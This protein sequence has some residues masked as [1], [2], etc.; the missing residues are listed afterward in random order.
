M[1][2]INQIL[3]LF[4]SKDVRKQNPNDFAKPGNYIYTLILNIFIHFRVP[5]LLR[6]LFAAKQLIHQS[7][8]LLFH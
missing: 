8:L 1:R 3:G 7:W 4:F 2:R 6:N 5:F